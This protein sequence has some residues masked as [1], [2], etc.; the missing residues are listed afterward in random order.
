ML[1]HNTPIIIGVLGDSAYVDWSN[2]G[3][4]FV[5]SAAFNYRNGSASIG[6]SNGLLLYAG[7]KNNI[8]P[9][10]CYLWNKFHKRIGDVNRIK[11]GLWYHASLFI[12]HPLNDSLIYLF[13]AGVTNEPYGLYVTTINYKANNDSGIVVQKNF[14]LNNFPAYDALMGVRHGNGRDWWVVFQ[15]YN[16]NFTTFYNDYYLFLISPLGISGPFIQNIGSFHSTNGGHV[17][18]SSDGSMYANVNPRGLIE[19]YNFDRC[20]GLITSTIPIEQEPA[21]G[22][23]PHWYGSCAFSP[24]DSKL[25][26]LEGMVNNDTAHIWQFDL[27][28]SN[29]AASKQVIVSFP[30]PLEGVYQM[31]LAPDNKIYI[32]AFDRNFSWPYPDTSIAFTTINNN[33]S[34]INYPDSLGAACDFQ[35]FSFNLGPGRSYFGLPNNPDYEL[36]AWVGS[37]CDTLSVGVDDNVPQQ[38]VFFQAW[39]NSEWNMIHV[40]ASKLKGRTGSLRLFDMEGRLVFEKKV[41]VIAGGYVTTEISMQG[42]AKGMYIVNLLTEKEYLSGKVMK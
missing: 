24:D 5:G 21:S 16:A 33:L 40:N 39:Y 41:E 31:K 29:I 11:G 15:R 18:F 14:Q 17:I 22:P 3:S 2:P 19:L 25:Y 12:P 7:L 10:D 28:A 6:D 30:D 36:G 9:L 38:Q 8:A 23:Y 35:P 13:T 37:P 34:V 27:N 4:P 26:V 42:I 20:T 32:S 1:L